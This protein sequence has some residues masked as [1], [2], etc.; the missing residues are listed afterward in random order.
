[1][2]IKKPWRTMKWGESEKMLQ[3]LQ[4]FQLN[5]I[6]EHLRILVVG[7]AGAGKSAFITSVNTAIQG[8]NTCLAHSLSG[9]NNVTCKYTIY[10]LDIDNDGSYPFLF[11]DTMGLEE[12]SSTALTKDI[13]SILHGHVQKEYPFN[14]ET[15]LTAESNYY[16][17]TPTLS[18]KVHCLVFVIPA[19][20]ID[21]SSDKIVDQIKEILQKAH[22][23]GIPVVIVMSKVDKV[24]PHV[25]E[26]LKMIYR[27]KKI[28]QKLEECSVNL[29]VPLN[30]IFPVKNYHDEIENNAE[31][32]V[33]LLTAATNIVN[34]A[35]DFVK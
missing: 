28:K 22:D 7:P 15:E 4:E 9:G 24:C 31:V 2:L 17:K 8:R 34:F 35:N 33:L 26:D 11:G 29:G 10:S 20:R 27:S 32:D 25:K 13:I 19:D 16:N 21:S 30:Y 6:S 14:S 1:L 12:G 18:D 5:H 23:L 3:K